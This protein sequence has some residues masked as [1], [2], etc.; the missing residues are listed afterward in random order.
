MSGGSS[1]NNSWTILTPEEPATETLRPLAEAEGTEHHG[2]SE[3]STT[4][5]TDSGEESGPGGGAGSTSEGP[6]AEDPPVAEETTAELNG[7]GGTDAAEPPVFIPESVSDAPPPSSSDLH[8]GDELSQS[9]GLPEG[10]AQSSPDPDSFSDSVTHISPSPEEPRASL[11]STETLG[12]AEFTQEET[13]HSQNG[14][15]LHQEGEE[16]ELS[17]GMTDLGKQADSHTFPSDPPVYSEAGEEKTAKME[18]EGESEVRRRRRSLLATLEQ[19]GRREEHEEAEE[20]FRLPQ[21]DE[22][23]GLSLN[24]CILGAFILLGI[25]TIF[26]SGV[27]MDPDEESDYGA[28]K[29]KDPDVPVKQEWLNPDV[30]PPPGG[31]ADNV[32]LLTKLA[33]GNEQIAVLQAQLQA[34]TEELKVA[35]GQAAEGAKEQLR[36]EGV[37]E[38]NS[39]LKEEMAS[40]PVLQR[41]NERMKREL[42]SLPALQKEVETL[43][44]TVTELRHS[45][46]NEA[47][48]APVSPIASPSSGLGED[49]MQG[50]AG[51]AATQEEHGAP[52]KKEWKKEK[53]DMGEKKEWKERDASDRK[54]GEKRERKDGGSKERKEKE[55][56]KEKHEQGKYDKEGKKKKNSEERKEWK[57]DK[58]SKGDEDKPR[59]DR[60]G[61]KEWKEKSEGKEW[62]KEKDWKKGKHEEWNEGK[63]GRGKEKKE[64]KG[65]KDHGER[66]KGKDESKGEREWK[67]GKNGFREDGKEWKE[68]EWKNERKSSKEWKGKQEKKDWDK[69]DGERKD[70]KDHGKQWK[71]KEERKEW[72]GKEERREWKKEEKKKDHKHRDEHKYHHHHDPHH[73]D[74]HEEHVWHDPAEQKPPHRHPKERLEHWVQQREEVQHK[75]RVPHQCSSVESCAA[76]QGLLPVSLS[77]FEPILQGYLAK[78]EGAGVD[79]GKTEELRKLTTE[80]FKD[81]VFVHDQMSYRDFVE[82]VGDVL[83]DMVEEDEELEDEMDGFEREVIKRFAAPKSTEKEERMKGER[84]KESIR[85][86]G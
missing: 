52:R 32:E 85:G 65:G 84:R 22:D 28:K 30:P 58:V 50:A 75:P 3:T 47:A 5:H 56:K 18:E 69:N 38:E 46:A 2:E 49:S 13:L 36:R 35:K 83:E 4:K 71:G 76:A 25:G 53:H 81:G 14:E 24:K 29:L 68:K 79:A 11:L 31:E 70:D 37:E 19:I 41:E 26:F 51:A 15:E 33:K 34:Q 7:V 6:P 42:D 80:F 78:A 1:T 59:N 8:G 43:R 12:G 45:T 9:E 72:K 77:D 82:D 63:H 10:P 67:K 54:E 44:A 74:H 27:F 17:P 62:K 61:K 73:H 16:S 64:W 66:R 48:P 86:R 57:K 23:S 55:W 20:E 60:E 21:R 40:V 39:R